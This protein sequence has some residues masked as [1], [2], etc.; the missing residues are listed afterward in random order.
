MAQL[1]IKASSLLEVIIAMVII[2]GVFVAAIGIYSKITK[3]SPSL[4]QQ[5]IRRTAENFILES[6][7]NQDLSK[8]EQQKDSLVFKKSF[9]SMEGYPDLEI[10]EITVIERGKEIGNVKRII[11]KEINDQQ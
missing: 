10:V 1:R 7:K 11:K 2:M 9:K 4:K 5:Y 6:V 3:Y 8:V